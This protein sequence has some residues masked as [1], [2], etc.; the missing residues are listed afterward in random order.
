MK[1]ATIEY[2]RGLKVS[3]AVKPSP[4]RMLS[5]NKR[6]ILDKKWDLKLVER[7]CLVACN[8]SRLA[9]DN[10]LGQSCSSLIMRS[11]ISC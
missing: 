4:I 5:S 10:S 6:S 2:A 3:C 8:N 9:V 7:T 1:S 11:G